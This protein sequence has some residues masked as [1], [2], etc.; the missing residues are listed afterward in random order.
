MPTEQLARQLAAHWIDAWNSHD[1]EAILA[2]Y[3]EDVVVVSPVA[4]SLLSDPSGTV[5]GKAALRA[6]FGRGLE[7]FPDLRFRLLDLMWGLSS[8]V[9]YYEDHNG[10]RAGEFME[11]DAD[12]RVVRMFANYGSRGGAA[13]GAPEARTP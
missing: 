4:A 5:R 1:L 10:T 2:H 11:L 9:L 3:A 8:V 12:G 13:A 7:A 6:Y